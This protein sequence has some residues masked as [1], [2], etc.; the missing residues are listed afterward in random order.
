MSISI[1]TN[2]PHIDNLLVELTTLV[3]D[4]G[5]DSDQVALFISKHEDDSW[6]DTRTGVTHFF[7]EIAEPLSELMEG[8]KNPEPGE[9]EEEEEDS[10]DLD[11]LPPSDWWKSDS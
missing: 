6:M 11:F 1:P 10:G 5:K 4:H 9:V 7:S 8:I 2:D 3:K